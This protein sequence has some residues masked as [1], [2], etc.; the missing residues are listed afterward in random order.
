VDALKPTIVVHGGA[1]DIPDE[2]VDDHLSGVKLAAETGMAVL[3]RVGRVLDAVEA[4]INVMEESGV[5]NAGRGSHLNAEGEV[6]MD[7]IIM[8]GETLNAGSVAAVKNI[9]HPISLAR[10]VMEETSHVLLVGEGARKFAA[11]HGFR[12]TPTEQLLSARE[13]KRYR[14]LRRRRVRPRQFYEPS[15]PGTVGA[16]ALD[17]HGN[18][19]AG[20]STGGQ[21][22][23]LPGRVGDSPLIGA[24]A[25]ADNGLGAC[26]ATG[27]GESI[28]KT[29][30]SKATCDF[31]GEGSTAQSA[32][33]K[34]IRVLKTKVNGRGGLIAI[35]PSGRHGV[36]HNT[37]RMARAFMTAGM[38]LP[39]AII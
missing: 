21:P 37:P 14:E 3:L 18:L 27:W 33:R 19:A 10:K 15:P 9:L 12:L 6:E 30:L 4:A 2:A 17:S 26:S 35:D 22:K 11:A 38:R 36:A 23:K 25:Y 32:C 20:T 28:M 7:A 5:F 16:V 29:V 24:G 39:K 31:M 8:D 34:A 1:W 13:L